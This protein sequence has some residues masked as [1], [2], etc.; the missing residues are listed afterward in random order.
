LGDK[1][2]ISRFKVYSPDQAYL[3][4]PSVRDELG[5]KHFCFFVRGVVERLDMRVFEQSYSAEGGEL[6]APQLMLGV[7]L[8]PYGLGIASA[9][10][11]ERRLVEDLSFRYLG[12]G[13]RVD[14]WA[15]SA[16]RH[17]HGRALNDAFTQVLEVGSA[18][19]HGEAGPC[20]D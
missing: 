11:V 3:L 4:S 1:R 9:R 15:L 5:E 12:A 18:A 16:F 10:Q 2:S 7:W 13:E 17:R 19:G 20:G 14:N 8:Y 6:Y